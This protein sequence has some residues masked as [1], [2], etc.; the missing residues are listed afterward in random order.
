MKFFSTLQNRYLTWQKCPKL[1]RSFLLLTGL[2]MTT[3]LCLGLAPLQ[4]VQASDHD[5]GEVD[6]KGRNLNLTDL[7]VFREKDQNSSASAEDLVFV[8]NTN[9]RSIARQQYYFSNTARYEFYI[10]RVQNNDAPVTGSPDVILRFEFEAPQNDQTQTYIMTAIRDG[11]SFTTQGKTT[12]LSQE[13]SPSIKQATFDGAKLSVFAGLREDPF[14]FDVE[15]FFRVRAGALGIGKAVGFRPASEAVDFAAGYNVNAITVRV[16]RKFLQAN[17]EATTFD[18]W[19]TISVPAGKNKDFT[20]VERLGRPAVNEGLIVSNSFLNSLNSVTPGFEAAA[21]KG[22]T[23][24]STVAAPIVGEAIQTLK[25]I[26]NNDERAT[27]LIKAFLPDVM[28]IDTREASGYGNALNALGS[29]IRGR[30]LTDDVIDIT[31]SVLTNGA[32]TGDNVSY[33]GTPGNSAQGHDPL[34]N[35]FPYLALPN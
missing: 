8:M 10:S 29:P 18:V 19:Q 31:L 26:G 35:Q 1:K 3:G 5:D 25:A 21:L 30:M 11:K 12:P 4:T 17:S 16:P 28:R 6:I 20:Q 27:A 33:A 14:F 24:A 15:Q 13:N 7:Y 23:P 22:R 2:M 34:S 32:I 9:P